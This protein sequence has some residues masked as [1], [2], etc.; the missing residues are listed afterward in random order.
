[1]AKKTKYIKKC[2]KR[3]QTN[4]EAKIQHQQRLMRKVRFLIN[5]CI[6]KSHKRDSEKQIKDEADN[7]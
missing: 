4:K 3:S 2:E 1:M 6:N 7:Q 5:G